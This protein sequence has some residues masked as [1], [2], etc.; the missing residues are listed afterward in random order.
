MQ[1]LEDNNITGRNIPISDWE[2]GKYETLTLKG[3]HERS[4]TW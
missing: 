4:D 1:A 2:G 3:K